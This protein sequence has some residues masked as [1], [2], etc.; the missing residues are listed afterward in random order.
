[1]L[2]TE[3][4]L[5]PSTQY[6]ILLILMVGVSEVILWRTAL[7]IFIL[8]KMGLSFVILIYGYYLWR[9]QFFIR[10]IRLQDVKA[11]EWLLNTNENDL[12][13]NYL[14]GKLQKDS[15]VTN[16]IC[17]LRF[18]VAGRFFPITCIIFR[19]TLSQEQ[20]RRLVRGMQCLG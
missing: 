1:M 9:C 17:I 6:L 3:F 8:F 15:T 19:D 12:N 10:S 16:I 4:N 13:E 18:Q 5:R 7:P 20:Y 2:E 11:N 14:I